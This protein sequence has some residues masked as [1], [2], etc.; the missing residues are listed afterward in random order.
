MTKQLDVIVA[1]PAGNIT[2]LVV[3]PVEI[4]DY[5]IISDKL[6]EIDFTN[7][8]NV[9]FSEDNSDLVIGE[10]VGFILPYSSETDT[11]PSMNMS[12]LE[13]CGNASR[14]FAYYRAKHF[15]DGKLQPDGTRKL[16]INVSG[17]DHPLT[18]FINIDKLEAK[19]Q[20][21]I[22]TD[23]VP[24]TAEELNLNQE[25]PDL[26]DIYMIDMGGISHLVLKNI[27]ATPEKF[28]RIKNYVY[29]KCGD[30]PAFGV[31]FMDK[32]SKSIT[33]VVYVRDVDTTY[34]EGSCASG[35]TAAAFGI[36]YDKPDGYYNFPFIEPAGTLYTNVTK[37]DGIITEIELYS[38]LEISDI[39]TVEI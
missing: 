9:H 29:Q 30:L 36:V 18:A 37:K 3:S 14:S 22:P 25:N 32:L 27:E 13:F 2:I 4:K 23:V 34:F 24:F 6:L 39:I 1:N 7:E 31:M 15:G 21:P 26:K 19:I 20:M 12:G 8:Y 17:C 33:P 5:Q 11:V 35:T 28:D 16:Q 38:H 10:Q